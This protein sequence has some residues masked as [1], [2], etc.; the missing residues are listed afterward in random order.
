MFNSLLLTLFAKLQLSPFVGRIITYVVSPPL[1]FLAY[2]FSVK[3]FLERS[4]DDKK[5]F[6]A[7][8]LQFIPFVVISFI[9]L[10]FLISLISRPSLTIF[11]F[12]NVELLVIYVTFKISVEKVLL[13]EKR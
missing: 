8:L 6:K 12:L 4:V 2:K 5:I 10:W 9:V 3:K 11:I 13:K 7:W 1:L